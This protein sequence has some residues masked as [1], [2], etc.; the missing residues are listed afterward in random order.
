MGSA[1]VAYALKGALWH[2]LL[3]GG[4]RAISHVQ[5]CLSDAQELA[6]SCTKYDCAT[7]WCARVATFGIDRRWR[8]G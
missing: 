3:H 5:C 8:N 4:G 2:A 1:P 7:T 6:V